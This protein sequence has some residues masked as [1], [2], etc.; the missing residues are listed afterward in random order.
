MHVSCFVHAFILRSFEQRR[1]LTVDANLKLATL[2]VCACHSCA[3]FSV[4]L[5]CITSVCQR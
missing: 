5:V 1:K 3:V 2:Y 4:Q